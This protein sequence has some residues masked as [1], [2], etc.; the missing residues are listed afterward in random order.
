VGCAAEIGHG[1]TFSAA[2]Q[3]GVGL[4]QLQRVA[5]GTGQVLQT[6]AQLSQ[7]G[8]EFLQSKSVQTDHRGA[9]TRSWQGSVSFEL[10]HDLRT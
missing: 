6:V 4:Q 1:F 5:L 7:R 3:Q 9:L 2:Q 10:V 8:V